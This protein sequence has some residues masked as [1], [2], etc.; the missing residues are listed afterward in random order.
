VSVTIRDLARR[1]NLSITTVSRALDGYNDVAEST[2][3]RVIQ[4]AQEIG[5]HPTSAAR[6]LRRKRSDAIGYILPTSSPRFSDPYYEKFLEGLC[7]QAA[8]Q[9]IDVIVTSCPPG[10][11]Q[12]K[13]VY[14]RWFESKKVDGFVL[15]RVRGDD[16]RIEFLLTKGVPFVALGKANGHEGYSFVEVNLQDGEVQLIQHLAAKGH[17]RIAFVGASSDLTIQV[18][19][20]SGF[21]LGLERAGLSLDECLVVQGDLT[22]DGGYRAGCELLRSPYPPTAIIAVNDLTA[23]GILRSIR[24]LGLVAGKDIAVAGLDGIKETEYSTPP[25]TTIS[26]PTYE[27]A[28]KL[29]NM[30]MAKIHGEEMAETRVEFKASL[31]IRSST[32]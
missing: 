13:S 29:A 18:E 12:E 21:K 10:S 28:R 7:D 20:Y 19:R 30:L 14:Q 17:T 32:G 8:E 16:S 11:D 4:I 31:I 15:N 9:S 3:Q 1:L 2:R 23:L 22:E 5:Y 6:Q 25:L 26:Q 27:I 24:E